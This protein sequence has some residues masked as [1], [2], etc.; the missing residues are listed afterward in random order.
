[1]KYQ[2]Y[3]K[4]NDFEKI[5]A[6]LSNV[7]GEPEESKLLYAKLVSA[8]IDLPILPEYSTSTI[9]LTLDFCDEVK[10]K[11]APDP[12]EW[13]VGREVVLDF[14]ADVNE[15]L[16]NKTV[17]NA[18]DVAAH[19]LYWST[20]YGIRTHTQHSEDFSRWPVKIGMGPYYNEEGEILNA[21]D[22]K[23]LSYSIDPDEEK[24]CSNIEEIE[25]SSCKRKRLKYWRDTVAYDEAIYWSWN[26][27]ILK[28]KLEYNIGYWRY[29]QRYVG[30]EKD[31]RRMQLCRRLLDLAA[32]DFPDMEGVY[33]NEHNAFRF[34]MKIEHDEYLELHLQDLRRE[35]AY[36]LVWKFMA[37]NMKK[38]WD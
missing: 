7:Y 31:V 16:L 17:Q 25:E 26:L 27:L 14:G 32:S 33:V 10:I 35:K 4:Q 36:Q 29:V 11:G 34:G 2:D 8:I 9:N 13:L 22:D 19:L 24:E 30:W 12:Q 3:F 6:T 18:S 28:K 21:L 23:P 5:W 37:E 20:M 1:M 38:W 15:S